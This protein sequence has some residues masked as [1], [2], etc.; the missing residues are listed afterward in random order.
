MSAIPRFT[1]F[2]KDGCSWCDEAEEWLEKRGYQ[3]DGIDVLSD[4]EEFAR[5]RELSGQSKCPTIV[6]GDESLPDFD[7]DQLD[8]WLASHGWKK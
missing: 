2:L 8:R 7:V 5:L 4:R 1:L 3:Y 6:A